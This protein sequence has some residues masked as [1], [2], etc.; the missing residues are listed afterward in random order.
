VAETWFAELALRHESGD[1]DFTLARISELLDTFERLGAKR[2]LIKAR[3]LKGSILKLKGSITEATAVLEHARSAVDEANS[4]LLPFVLF[5]LCDVY[6]ISGEWD[7]AERLLRESFV[8]AARHRLQTVVATL[9]AVA[10]EL[11]RQKGDLEGA[12]VL[13]SSA[14]EGA[15]SSGIAS[16]SARARLIKAE[17][18][19]ALNRMPEAR[20]ELRW[21]LEVFRAEKMAPEALASLALLRE[22]AS[23]IALSPVPSRDRKRDA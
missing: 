10:G 8:L 6:V 20:A 12:L 3:A 1:C 5:N 22:I 16:V 9:Q 4:D 23:R 13:F 14:V 7:Q 2:N 21:A 18:L 15:F 19:L 11:K 17:T